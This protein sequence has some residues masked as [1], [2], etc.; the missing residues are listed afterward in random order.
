MKVTTDQI[1]KMRKYLF[2]EGVC[3][4]EAKSNAL[5]P[6]LQ[7]PNDQVMKFMRSCLSRHIV[8]KVFVWRHAYF[9]LTD[10]GVNVLREEL[11][12]EE[13]DYPVTHVEDIYDGC[14]VADKEMI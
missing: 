4:V 7:I 6:D 14:A 8:E 10:V 11:C 9:F 5:H 1:V 3:L 13:G 12:Y 2:H